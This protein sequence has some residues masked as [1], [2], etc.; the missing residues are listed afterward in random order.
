[1]PFLR[2]KGFEKPFLQEISSELIDTFSAVAGVTKEK[3]KIELLAV[4]RITDTP[5]SLEIFMF[6]REQAKHDAIASAMYK[7]LAGHGH[8]HVHIFFVVLNPSLYYKEGEPLTHYPLLGERE[9]AL[10]NENNG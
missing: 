3:V 10:K 4:E 7:L 2:F 1:M 8:A 9:L 5:L 6:Q